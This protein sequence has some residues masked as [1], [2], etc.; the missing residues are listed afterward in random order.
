MA[1]EGHVDVRVAV[2]VPIVTFTFVATGAV[3]MRIWCRRYSRIALWADDWLAVASLV[4]QLALVTETLFAIVHGGLGRDRTTVLSEQGDRG[5]LVIMECIFAICITYGLASPAV[6]LTVLALLW[7]IFP[8]RFIRTGIYVIGGMCVAW[9]VA[10]EL[11]TIFQCSPIPAAWDK[12]LDPTGERC[13]NSLHFYTGNSAANFVLD[14]A[15]LILPVPEILHLNMSRTRKWAVV[16]VFA[17][18]TAV[19]VASGVR[20]VSTAA[21]T[22]RGVSDL[23]L[24]FGTPIVATLI[25]VCVAIIVACL[26]TCAPA[27]RAL[28]RRGTNVKYQ[29][30]AEWEPTHGS[31]SLVT[32]G[33]LSNRNKNFTKVEDAVDEE[34]RMNLNLTPRNYSDRQRTTIDAGGHSHGMSNDGVPLNQIT[35][36]QHYTWSEM[37]SQH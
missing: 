7:R 32:I 5:F 29:H 8:T 16:G 33:K 26:P 25:E 4:L 24:Q 22:R 6:K 9:F 10:V 21:L 35:L 15:I 1:S 12:T 27:Y 31:Y 28:C 37:T 13:I 34:S 23:S 11:V 30:R 3:A 20:L 17:L 14:L 19:V 2:A 36:K 18:G